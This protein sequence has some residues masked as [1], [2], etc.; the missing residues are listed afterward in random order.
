MSPFEGM[1]MHICVSRTANRNALSLKWPL[2]G[3]SLHHRVNFPKP[4]N[5]ASLMF[6]PEV[7]MGFLPNDVNPNLR[8]TI[9]WKRKCSDLEGVMTSLLLSLQIVMTKLILLIVIIY[10]A[11]PTWTSQSW[12][13]C[14][15]C[16][17]ITSPSESFWV[18]REEWLGGTKL[19]IN[20]SSFGFRVTS[21]PEPGRKLLTVTV[22]PG[23]GKGASITLRIKG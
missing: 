6:S 7:I 1:R 16:V 12:N 18:C 8:A 21:F 14:A 13:S 11:V 9:C 3:Q 19:L 23:A 17:P 15:Y 2:I 5:R 10:I 20:I 22:R 4:E